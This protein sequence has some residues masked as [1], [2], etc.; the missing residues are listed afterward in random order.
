MRALVSSGCLVTQ[1]PGEL[2]IML[3]AFSLPK[4]LRP[5]ALSVNY[6]W[7]NE[8]GR[9]SSKI[10]LINGVLT[11]NVNASPGLMQS[12]NLLQLVCQLPVL[13][14]K[15]FF[16]KQMLEVFVQKRFPKISIKK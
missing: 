15:Y 1:E 2:F 6:L 4:R 5:T 16:V 11:P 8:P 12:S 7:M 3:L 10:F 14:G 9:I 13:K